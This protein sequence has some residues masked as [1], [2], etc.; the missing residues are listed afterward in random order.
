MDVLIHMNNTQ[1]RKKNKN[2]AR[3][4][5]SQISHGSGLR[6]LLILRLSK[7]FSTAAFYAFYATRVYQSAPTQQ[8]EPHVRLT[9]PA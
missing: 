6:N 2:L 5:K 1:K 4:T 7:V 8:T 3:H 9:Q